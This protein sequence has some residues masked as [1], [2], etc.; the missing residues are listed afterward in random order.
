MN[1]LTD[2]RP[3]NILQVKQITAEND[4]AI[5]LKRM[6]ICE[7][8]EI[9]IIQLGDPLIL[10]VVGARIGINRRLAEM[11]DVEMIEQQKA[12]NTPPDSE[13]KEF[14]NPTE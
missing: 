3:G 9:Q 8:R 13:S 10:R 12:K 14:V 7:G 11:I 6:G 5:R 1:R 2:S 4:D